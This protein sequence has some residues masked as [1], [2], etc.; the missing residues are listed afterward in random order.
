MPSTPFPLTTESPTTHTTDQH[1]VPI[2][3]RAAELMP[4][5]A[6]RLA[7]TRSVTQKAVDPSMG[8]AL[9]VRL[10]A[11]AAS[12]RA[13]RGRPSS[14]YTLTARG[15]R[16]THR[17]AGDDVA[18]RRQLEDGVAGPSESDARK[19]CMGPIANVR[20]QAT[21][22]SSR[23]SCTRGS[24][25]TAASCQAACAPSWRIHHAGVVR[26][27]AT[28]LYDAPRCAPRQRPRRRCP[29]GAEVK[30]RRGPQPGGGHCARAPV[31]L[32]ATRHG[33]PPPQWCRLPPGPRL[34]PRHVSGR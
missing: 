1:H 34:G 10:T 17:S 9:R 23:S 16:A 20:R 7:L 22:S 18:W 33:A 24:T 19:S 25:A 3:P 2:D 4:I 13:S 8:P 21:R 32:A 30:L 26:A 27:A 6:A 29:L 12:A 14:F 11:R 31:G 28:A 5:H 15:V